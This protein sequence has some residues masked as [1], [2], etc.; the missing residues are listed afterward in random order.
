[1]RSIQEYEAEA[2][3]DLKVDETSIIP[4]SLRLGSLKRKWLGYL[5]EE[6][7]LLA[8]CDSRLAQLYRK[9]H[10]QIMT[11]SEIAV[12]RRDADMHVKGDDRYSE[13]SLACAAQRCRT[14]FVQDMLK[15][16]EN[17]SFL[18]NTAMKMMIFR[19]GGS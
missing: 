9:V 13:A 18:L 1:M 3:E 5:S 4:Y 8:E 6:K 7:L 2:A 15:T 16:L 19:E 14:E 17:Q 11:K 12:D 10:R